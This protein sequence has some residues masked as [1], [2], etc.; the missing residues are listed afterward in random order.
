MI[1]LI[2]I[3]WEAYFAAR[4]KNNSRK[5]IRNQQRLRKNG[6]REGKEW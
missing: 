5:G 4:I 1:I 6:L 3:E 2:I